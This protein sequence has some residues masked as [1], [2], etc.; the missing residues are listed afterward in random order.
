MNNLIDIGAN[1]TNTKLL[2]H[3]DDIL[4]RAKQ[5]QVTHMV[6]TGTSLKDSKTALSLAHQYPDQLS[7]TCGIHPHD[8]KEWN[9]DTWHELSQIIPQ[10]SVVAVGETGLD[11]NRNY[12]PTDQQI[13]AFEQQIAL[14]IEHQKPLFLHQREAH[15]TFFSLLKNQRD[16]L[17]KVVVH[18]FT[19]EKKALFDYLD[20]DFYIGVTG[21]VCDDKRGETL[22]SLVPSIPLNRLMV[23]TDAPYLLPKD[24][25][26]KPKPKFNEPSFLPHIVNK[27]AQLYQKPYA[28]ISSASHANSIDFFNLN[29]NQ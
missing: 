16:H 9:S 29:I 4:E 21:W 11:F 8:A 22:Q 28:E 14:S 1:L 19:D 23:E 27:I 2:A 24:L 13:I 17:P 25:K 3:I 15:D 7:A 26:L 10:P 18:C 20:Q 12:S 5:Q 6:V